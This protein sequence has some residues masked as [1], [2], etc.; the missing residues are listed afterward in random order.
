MPAKK[1]GND[2]FWTF[3]ED[4]WN[5][6][7]VAIWKGPEDT[8]EVIARA[9]DKYEAKTIVDALLNYIHLED[10]TKLSNKELA[11]LEFVTVN[12]V[13]PYSTIASNAII[14]NDR[15]AYNKLK[16][17]FSVIYS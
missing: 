13:E 5:G 10:K 2:Y 1:Y 9:K 12:C 14:W 4:G 17:E 7:E 11:F 15:E 6:K 8:A 16:S 3:I